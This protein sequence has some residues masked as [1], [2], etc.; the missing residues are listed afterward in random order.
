[1]TV[2]ELTPE[3]ARNLGVA[4]SKG[5]IV[6]NVDDGG[7]ADEAGLRRGDILLEANQKKIQS[8]QD[9]RA[10]IGRAR[11]LGI[12]APARSPWE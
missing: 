2:Q 12:A 4:D 9:Y 6:T 5:V 11:R 1:M 7:V 8:V 3:I 10:A